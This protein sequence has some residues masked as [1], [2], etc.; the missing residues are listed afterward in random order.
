MPS[1]I[2]ERRCQLGRYLMRVR[3]FATDAE[4]DSWLATEHSPVG[5]VGRGRISDEEARDL[6]S[7]EALYPAGLF[8]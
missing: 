4:A 8:V 5:E 2:I 1:A 3:T 6:R 7:A